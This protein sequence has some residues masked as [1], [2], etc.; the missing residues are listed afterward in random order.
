MRNRNRV[1]SLS[2]FRRPSAGDPVKYTES[3]ALYKYSNPRAKWKVQV[4]AQC[5]VEAIL[6]D[7]SCPNP[8]EQALDDRGSERT[9]YV[10]RDH[11]DER[12]DRAPG[13]ATFRKGIQ[14]YWGFLKDIGDDGTQR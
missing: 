13:S 11:L 7:I 10:V 12:V 3:H 14:K 4:G 6:S 1:E 2:A 9:V 5:R 8:Q